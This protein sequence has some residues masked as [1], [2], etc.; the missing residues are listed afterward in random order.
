[1]PLH[2]SA[3]SVPD[4]VHPSRAL[5]HHFCGCSGSHSCQAAWGGACEA[6]CNQR[7][8]C[9]LQDQD[10][11]QLAACK[12]QGAAISR[13]ISTTVQGQQREYLLKCRHVWDMKRE[14]CGCSCGHVCSHHLQCFSPLY[15]CARKIMHVECRTADWE[16]ERAQIPGGD[17]SGIVE[18]CD[19]KSKVLP[20]NQLLLC[21]PMPDVCYPRMN[22]VTGSV[23]PMIASC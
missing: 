4:L 23:L 2:A 6:A 15:V 3:R 20:P 21:A 22:S 8:P 9:G 11:S 16:G 18:E 12:T 17:V 1:M 5:F 13:R 14:G 7:E 10:P 19:V